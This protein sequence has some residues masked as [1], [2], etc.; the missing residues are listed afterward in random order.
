MTV[1][2]AL[3]GL[4]LFFSDDV[5]GT[6]FFGEPHSCCSVDGCSNSCLS[7]ERDFG[8]FSRGGGQRSPISYLGVLGLR[9]I[10]EN[11]TQGHD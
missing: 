1:V 8:S 3:C 7:L 9:I 2:H 5:P 11:L 4:T 6:A 10:S